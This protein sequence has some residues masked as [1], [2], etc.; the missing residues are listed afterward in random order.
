MNDLQ[1]DLRRSI[2][3]VAAP[4][5]RKIIERPSPLVTEGQIETAGKAY[6]KASVWTMAAEALIDG[7]RL[8]GRTVWILGTYAAVILVGLWAFKHWPAIMRWL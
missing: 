3:Y 8:V 5:V 1:N 7:A 4:K 6:V 2:G